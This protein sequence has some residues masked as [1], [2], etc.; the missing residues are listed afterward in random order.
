MKKFLIIALPLILFF[1][2]GAGF[3]MAQGSGPNPSIRVT[4]ENPFGS[5]QNS[6]FG[7]VRDIIN[8]VV[9]PIGGVIAVLAFIYSG[10]LYVTAQ[11]NEQKIK[12]AHRALLYT[13]IGA[14]VLL[15]AW[16]IANVVCT[17]IAALGGPACP[18]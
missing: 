12:D 9:L 8:D 4:L 10:F 6:L 2:F 17:T 5:Q 11:G 15:G 13:S 7:L 14:A 3:V 16:V 1:V 18:I